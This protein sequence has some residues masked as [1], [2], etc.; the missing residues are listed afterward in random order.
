MVPRRLWGAVPLHSEIFSVA[1]LPGERR[2]GNISATHLATSSLQF[3]LGE[4]W[5]NI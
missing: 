1:V 3:P 4:R 5:P 2:E